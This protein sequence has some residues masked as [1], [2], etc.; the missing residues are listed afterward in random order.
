VNMDNL[1]SQEYWAEVRE[2]AEAARAEEKAG[3]E[4]SDY[5]HEQ[6]D[7]HQWIIYTFYN[8]QVLQHSSSENAWF[9]EFGE[10]KADDFSSCMAKLAYAAMAT[11]VRDVMSRLED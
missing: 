3:G 8:L 4:A 11:D 10:M 9:E 7:S 5:I 6:I 2:I 1:S